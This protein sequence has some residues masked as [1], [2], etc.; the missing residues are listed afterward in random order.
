M[1]T[2][3]YSPGTAGMVAHWLLIEL[4]VAHSLYKVD[5]AGGEHK[6]PA[7]LAL[8]PSGVLPTLVV[9][10]QPIC[11]SGAIAMYIADL[12]PERGFAPAPATLARGSY[13]QW[14]V[15][16]ANTLQPSYR[17]RF[18]PG[19]PAG[20][21]AIDAVRA[22]SLATIERAWQR[23]DDHLAAHGPYLLGEQ[24]TTPDFLAT[25]LMRWSR[26]FPR[27]AAS[28]PAVGRLAGLMKARP[29]FKEVYRREGLTDWT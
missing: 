17:A 22:H 19:E 13:Y 21:S 10:G 16:L 7:Y 15:F 3:Y 14:M 2:L 8:N 24:P 4:E 9:D 1:I 25:M 23:I 5:F 12:R 29:G 27:P 6:Q 11:E 28:W 26:N 20:E 18:Y